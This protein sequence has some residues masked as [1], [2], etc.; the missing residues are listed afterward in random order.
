MSS[1]KTLKRIQRCELTSTCTRTM[2]L[3]PL[4]SNSLGLYLLPKAN[5]SLRQ[6]LV[7]LL[8]MPLSTKVRPWSAVKR[9]KLWK[10]NALQTRVSVNRKDK[11]HSARKM[12]ICSRQLSSK[13]SPM[14][15]S[16]L[17]HRLNRRKVTMIRT[18]R[19]WKRTSRMCSYLSCSTGSSLRWIILSMMMTM[20]RLRMLAQQHRIAVKYHL[21]QMQ[22]K[23]RRRKNES[24]L[25]LGSIK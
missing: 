7:N 22:A 19:V 23:R 11:R 5:K 15:G 12:Q 6:P 13:R 25:D 10:L 14:Q 20:N 18:G 4:S 16:R 24:W 17:Q 9:A 3:S 21:L 8:P 1:C 2:M